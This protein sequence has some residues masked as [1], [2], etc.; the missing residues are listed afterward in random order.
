MP[1]MPEI[2]AIADLSRVLERRRQWR[3][4]PPALLTYVVAAAARAT[5]SCAAHL[6]PV[7][8]VGVVVGA[9]RGVIR[10]AHRMPDVLVDTQ[11]Q[12]VRA[13]TSEPGG[14]AAV[15]VE[16][17]AP[18]SGEP[19]PSSGGLE[20]GTPRDIGCRTGPAPSSVPIHLI[21]QP[22]GRQLAIEL[23][24]TASDQVKYLFLE[25]LVR[26]LER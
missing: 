22:S 12:Q 26:E 23:L 15:W 11:I 25:R 14:R 8:S 7:D 4:T 13:G 24:G 6:S 2:T 1:P 21:G 3:Y 19:W 10:D 5:R 16:V 18:G 9:T 17:V 20:L